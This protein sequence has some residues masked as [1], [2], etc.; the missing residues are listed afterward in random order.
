MPERATFNN[1][2]GGINNN[3]PPNQI[4]DNEVADALNV[5]FDKRS[6]LQVRPGL[7]RINY[8]KNLLQRTEEF[9]N[10]YWEKINTPVI[11]ANSDTAPDST[12][13][14]DT[15]E[16]DS[17]VNIE[18]IRKFITV[19]DNQK[20]TGSVHIKKTIGKVTFPVIRLEFTGGTPVTLL[21]FINTN[22]G[23]INVIGGTGTIEDADD[24][25][26][27]SGTVTN[28]A[29]G[30]TNLEFLITPSWTSNLL[31][32]DDTLVGSNVFWGAQLERGVLS[33]YHKNV[34]TAPTQSSNY[35]F[36]NITSIV[37]YR[38]SGGTSAI[39]VTAGTD[40]WR[41]NSSNYFDKITGGLT[42]PSGNYWKW[43][44]YDDVLIGVNRGSNDNPV[45]IVD[46]V[47]NAVALGGSPPK[48][49][50]IVVWNNRIWILKD[51]VVTC[52]ALGLY[53]DYSAT[54]KAGSGDFEIGGE[55]G[56]LCTG[57]VVH[58]DRLFIFKSTKIYYI[59]PGS[60][61]TDIEQYEI[62]EFTSNIGCVSTYSIQVILDDVIF[63]SKH[64]LTSLAA[65]EQ[66]G[67]F[68]ESIISQKIRDLNNFRIE[69]VNTASVINPQD[70]QYMLA[71]PLQGGSIHTA[72][73][74]MDYSNIQNRAVGFTRFNGKV[75][76]ASLASVQFNGQSRVYVGGYTQTTDEGI[77]YLYRYGDV[78]IYND[79]G[80]LYDII[81]ETKSHSVGQGINNA[82]FIRVYFILELIT[83]PLDLS[84]QYKFNESSAKIKSW[85]INFT[86]DIYIG[87][88]WDSGLWDTALW[89]SPDTLE[90]T[91]K[92]KVLGTP[93]RLARSIQFGISNVLKDQAFTFKAYGFDFELM[94]HKK[95]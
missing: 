13:T 15:I 54:G 62:K 43:I 9:D 68:A 85:S 77:A 65:V 29:S 87:A 69:D 5:I 88:V 27:V 66:Y 24:Y 59:L 8:N 12:L 48:G 19:S 53:E 71:A 31:T 55:E 93:G 22:T 60:P 61:N 44:V 4:E 73:W 90:R 81:I 47:S 51:N 10:V 16:D 7:T 26:R 86:G 25:W 91:I 83:S 14:A 64:G 28:N 18:Y 40:I 89:A 50:D 72:L 34:T 37:D 41:L 78:N 82:E 33:R 21:L 94:S 58:K 20:Y 17:N 42:L 57:M 76:G 84:L 38:L 74:V 11:T 92:R 79:D 80:S 32:T 1:F 56:D 23:V 95:D 70:S 6:N 36:N 30:N 35:I 46:T 52:S 3:S 75:I 2:G 49:S 39:I 63:L 67:D 45:K